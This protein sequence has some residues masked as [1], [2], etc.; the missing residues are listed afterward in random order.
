MYL[1]EKH[2]RKL[3]LDRNGVFVPKNQHLN[4]RHLRLMDSQGQLG[5]LHVRQHDDI[6]NIVVCTSDTRALLGL[7][8]LTTCLSEKLCKFDLSFI[9]IP[10][11]YSDK[12]QRQQLH[13]QGSQKRHLSIR[14]GDKLIEFSRSDHENQSALN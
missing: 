10:R 1:L 13:Y 5:D 7:E 8:P 14:I 11:P 12:D 4:E 3:R 6:F 9:V 2:L